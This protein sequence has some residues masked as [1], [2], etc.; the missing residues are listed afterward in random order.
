MP[1]RTPPPSTKT[2][3]VILILIILACAQY[4]GAPRDLLSQ[5]SEPRSLEQD[6]SG[7]VTPGPTGIPG[8]PSLDIPIPDIPGR[9]TSRY[10]DETFLDLIDSNSRLNKLLDEFV[11]T[12][13]RR[14]VVYALA[15]F[16]GNVVAVRIGPSKS[17][18]AVLRD[19]NT[20]TNLQT[21]KQYLKDTR[22][23]VSG[24]KAREQLKAML[25]FDN[26]E[27]E[28]RGKIVLFTDLSGAGAIPENFQLN[29]TTMGSKSLAESLRKLGELK[30]A[31]L[32]P[33]ELLAIL[34]LPETE[35]EYSLVFDRGNYAPLSRWVDA[36]SQFRNLAD[37]HGVTV[38]IP[39]EFTSDDPKTELLRQIEDSQGVL[40][41]VAH[42]DRGYI[43][44]PGV[45]SISI[46]PKDIAELHLKHAPVV[47]LR[48]CDGIDSGFPD[49]FL[50]AGAVAVS[51]NIGP[52]R[53]AV[54]QEQIDLFLSSLS[55]D[56][57]VYNAL[58]SVKKLNRHARVATNLRTELFPTKLF[59]ADPLTGAHRDTESD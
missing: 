54:A 24:A 56:G 18:L 9:S 12:R 49:A 3:T 51:A 1:R 21:F 13:A 27:K 6:R 8:T 35:S 10:G 11:K 23:P 46:S 30:H 4:G 31:T 29:A 14:V 55:S 48:V 40:L 57:S 58:N 59:T 7:G 32:A 28:D 47:F 37:S 25:G 43:R 20:K 36:S 53:P 42:A 52:I 2:S 39:R 17:S 19:R 16:K 15:L 33:G 50:R 22:E 5:V 38:I 44:L 34:G 41:F 45:S 26:T